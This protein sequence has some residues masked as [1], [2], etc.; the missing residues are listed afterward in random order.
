MLGVV[1]GE[2]KEKMS[3]YCGEFLVSRK[4]QEWRAAT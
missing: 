3:A 2:I 4:G 1:G